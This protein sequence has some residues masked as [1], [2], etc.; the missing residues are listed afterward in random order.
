MKPAVLTLLLLLCSAKAAAKGNGVGAGYFMFPHYMGA[1]ESYAYT[2]FFPF[3]ANDYLFFNEKKPVV[4][5][6][7]SQ[8]T[9]PLSGDKRDAAPPK[10]FGAKDKNIFRSGSYARRGMGYTPPGLFLGPK[11]GF[12]TDSFAVD[13]ASMAGFQLGKG[14]DH[15]GF[16]HRASVKA[17]LLA[18]R[19]AKSAGCLCLYLDGYWS[20][21]R[22]NS[23]YYGITSEHALPERPIYNADKAGFL[24]L[25]SRL[26]LVKR[27]E[28]WSVL[29][30]LSHQ[31]MTGSIVEDSPLVFKVEG[32]SAGLGAAYLLSR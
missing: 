13:F 21:S 2:V 5:K 19:S 7:D 20:S 8:I 28:S 10:G 26:Y 22:Y 16:L 4:F 25:N 24:G 12:K 3:V 9:L 1:S 11:L 18:D 17:A 23:T 30:F 14:W 31:N 6:L 15:I 27:W 32:F 29:A